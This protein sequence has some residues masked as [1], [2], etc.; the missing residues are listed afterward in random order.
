[1]VPRAGFELATTR[2]SAGCS[3]RLSYLGA[4]DINMNARACFLSFLQVNA[5]EKPNG[6]LVPIWVLL[7]IR[8]RNLERLA[9]PRYTEPWK[10]VI[11]RF[12][13]FKPHRG[14][15]GYL[16]CFLAGLENHARER[17]LYAL[18]DPQLVDNKFS[19]GVNVL[20]FELY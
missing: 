15:N 19:Y 1:M 9:L 16:C 5:S 7:E 17:L 12:L 2:S 18:N 13:F 3:P 6:L 10:A 11:I 20:G 14:F 4:F 8:C